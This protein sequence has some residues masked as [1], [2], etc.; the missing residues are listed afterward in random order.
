MKLTDDTTVRYLTMFEDR[1]G[2]PYTLEGLES[3]VHLRKITP[4]TLVCFEGTDDFFP[5]RKSA[6]GLVLFKQLL[7]PQAAGEWAPPGQ[8]ND[9]AFVQRKRHRLGEAKFEKV[10]SAPGLEP[11]IDVLDLLD[12]VR[13][14]EIESGRDLVRPHRLR[15]SRRNRDFWIMLFAGN[16]LLLGGAFCLQNTASF[17]FGIAG[18]GLFTFGLLWSMYGVMDNY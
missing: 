9:P 6:L 12:E 5:I 7:Q 18:S 11:R 2:G 1:I 15:F 3:L 17:V 13:Q 14:A 8:E 4:D 10:N 16:G